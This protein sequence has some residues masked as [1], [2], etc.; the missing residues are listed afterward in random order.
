MNDQDLRSELKV[1]HDRIEASLHKDPQDKDALS[2]IMTDL[3]RLAE[4]ENFHEEETETLKEQID[5]K[6]TDFEARHPK[7]AGV[8]REVMDV[9][10]KLG[11]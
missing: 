7:V 8:M 1:L 3:V 6:A 11:F 2:H 10:A 5:E 4:G 9:L